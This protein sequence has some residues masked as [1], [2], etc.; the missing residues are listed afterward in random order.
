[1]KK[2]LFAL[3]SMLVLS[4]S[5]MAVKPVLTEGFDKFDNSFKLDAASL[6]ALS[7][8]LHWEHYTGTRFSY[9]T[10]VQAHFMNRSNAVRSRANEEIPTQVELDGKMYDLDWTNHPMEW[11]ADVTMNGKV[12]EVK[13]DRKFVGVMVS[14]EAR[15]YWGRRPNRGFYS[16]A[17]VDMGMFL[18]TFI[19]SVTKQSVAD[20]KAL[21][22]ERLAKA[23]AEGRDPEEAKLTADE[24]WRKAGTE[25][26]EIDFAL[27]C[28]FGIGC[29]YWFGRNSHWGLD[30]NCYLKS[31][32]KIGHDENLWEWLWGVG[33]PVDLNVA[34]VYRF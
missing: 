14:P 20:Q 7:P 34:L 25:M 5:M 30:T 6:V 16:A 23:Q 1:M 15:L 26:G 27:G 29:Q 24:K 12:H 2:T 19:V 4:Q 3:A 22:Q 31:D 17:R 32:W 13:W 8:Q 9:G 10:Y 21:Y 33:F 18:E 11:Y 28:G